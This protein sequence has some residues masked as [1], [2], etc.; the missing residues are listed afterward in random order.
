MTH[1]HQKGHDRGIGRGLRE[2]LILS[3]IPLKVLLLPQPLQWLFPEVSDE[4]GSN[5]LRVAAKEGGDPGELLL[6]LRGEP[7]DPAEGV[8]DEDWPQQKA[9]PVG[10][11]IVIEL[12]S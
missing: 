7:G 9:R 11:V 1:L 6:L 2:D 12:G 5:E 4:P 3:Q 10:V 8:V